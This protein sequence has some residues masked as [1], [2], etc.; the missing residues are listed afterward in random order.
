MN[1][2]LKVMWR[3][4]LRVVLGPRAGGPST[5]WHLELQP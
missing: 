2:S 4:D 1:V 5:E 3:D